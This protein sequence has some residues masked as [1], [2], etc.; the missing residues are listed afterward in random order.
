MLRKDW[1]ASLT[2]MCL[3]V[4]N[5]NTHLGIFYYILIVQNYRHNLF[6]IIA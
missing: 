3:Y 2:G 1:V 4:E 6:K 5:I